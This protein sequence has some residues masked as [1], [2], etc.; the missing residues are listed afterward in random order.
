[1]KI[2]ISGGSGF[3][4][5]HLADDLARHHEV[6][7]IGIQKNIIDAETFT[8]QRVPYYYCDY[9]V[10]NIAEILAGTK[11]DAVVNLAAHRPEPGREELDDYYA[12]LYTAANMFEACLKKDIYNV[13]NISSRMV[14]STASASPWKETDPPQPGSYY[15]LSKQWAENAADFFNRKGMKIKTLRLAQ[16]IG[17]GEREGY[18]LQVLLNN[19]MK[20][21]P[22]T[23]FGQCRGKRHYIYVKDVNRAIN[24]A[25]SKPEMS[26]I[27]NIGMADI[28]GFDEL[29]ATINRVFGNKSEIIIKKEAK[30]DENIYHMSIEKAGRELDWEPAYDLAETYKDIKNDLTN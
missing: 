8:K 7:V 19:A 20:G 29:A 22:I 14:Y 10:N 3:I 15:A 1:M 21:L 2:A 11:P 16:V 5:R 27:F 28:Y 9:A 25:L 13:I 18:L 17:P 30:A 24:A 6:F 12:N 23:V 4:G 26:G